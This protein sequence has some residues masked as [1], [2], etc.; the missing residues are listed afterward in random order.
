LDLSDTSRPNRNPL[1]ELLPPTAG[2]ATVE[3]KDCDG[4]AL[5]RDPATYAPCRMMSRFEV[6]TPRGVCNDDTSC[7]RGREAHGLCDLSVIAAGAILD[8]CTADFTSLIPLPL[9]MAAQGV[10]PGCHL[11]CA[12]RCVAPGWEIGGMEDSISW[13]STR[14]EHQSD[15]SSLPQLGQL[16][17]RP[18]RARPGHPGRAPPGRIAGA[19]AGQLLG[20]SEQP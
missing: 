20:Q 8:Q 5:L 14:Q 9:Q 13:P 7:W 3:R 19:S 4:L 10:R 11:A 15:Q 16:S 6:R 12:A 2:S 18:T 1:L 17:S